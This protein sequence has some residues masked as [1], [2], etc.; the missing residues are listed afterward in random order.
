MTPALL[1]ELKEQ[2]EYL[3][4]L[5]RY[6]TRGEGADLLETLDFDLAP[7]FTGMGAS[8]HAA[9]IAGLHLQRLGRPARFLEATDLLFYSH[10][11]LGSRDLVVYVSQSGSSAEVQLVLERLGN[12]RLLAITN[13]LHSPLA[14]GARWI[15]LLHAGSENLIASKTYINSL[16]LLWL[17]ARKWGRIPLEASLPVLQ[18]LIDRVELLVQDG[19]S[20]AEAL[21]G[22]LGEVERLIFAGHGP[23]AATA[24]QAAM[25]MSEWARISAL[26]FSAGGLRHGFIEALGPGTGAVLFAAPGASF[27]SMTSLAEELLSYGVRVMLVSNGNVCRPGEVHAQG[28]TV[29]EFLSPILDILPVQFLAD[30]TAEAYGAPTGFRRIQKVIKKL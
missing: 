21:T 24:R 19:E 1:L 27:Q 12:A 7:L 2:P 4:A 9:W 28:E 6:Y 30:R 13:D 23:H 5:V 8:Y 18:D 10:P 11:C 3:R 15:L 20:R 25:I 22:G 29:D 17:A 26:S 16:A 14:R